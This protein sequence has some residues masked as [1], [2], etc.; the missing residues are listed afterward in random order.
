MPE[1][2]VS[3]QDE[4]ESF[5]LD[6]EHPAPGAVD[7]RAGAGRGQGDGRNVGPA[8]DNVVHIPALGAVGGGVHAVK[9][10]AEPEGGPGEGGQA[11]G[12]GN[13]QAAGGVRQAAPIILAGHG[14]VRSTVIGRN[15]DDGPVEVCASFNVQEVVEREAERPGAC[16]EGDGRRDDGASVRDPIVV[17]SPARR[18]FQAAIVKAVAGTV[19]RVQSPSGAQMPQPVAAAEVVVDDE[20]LQAAFE[21][22]AEQLGHHCSRRGGQGDGAREVGEQVVHAVACRQ[23]RREGR[24]HPLG[25]GDRTPGEV[26]QRTDSGDIRH[27]IHEAGVQTVHH[28]SILGIE[29]AQEMRAR[30]DGEGALRPVHI[31]ADLRLESPVDGES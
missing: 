5:G 13:P 15:G 4:V 6:G 11:H 16:R 22:H 31:T 29:P 14:G 9:G 21:I 7:E 17:V 2:V 27:L 28:A 23:G 25:R 1:A 3:H 20:A 24:V 26:M 10:E 30:R 18:G 12:V 19:A 8:D